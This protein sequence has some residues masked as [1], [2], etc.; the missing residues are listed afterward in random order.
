MNR[1]RIVRTIRM[2]QINPTSQDERDK[3]SQLVDI[4]MFCGLIINPSLLWI[5]PTNAFL[6]GGVYFFIPYILTYL[7]LAFPLIHLEIFVGQLHQC[8]ILAI[9]RRY[10]WAFQSI[11]ILI[12]IQFFIQSVRNIEISYVALEH[13]KNVLQDLTDMLSC[14]SERYRG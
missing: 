12:F 4:L 13:V 10:G 11:G 6:Y 9:F 5:S 2:T 14:Q 3:R 8:N 7:L 1:F